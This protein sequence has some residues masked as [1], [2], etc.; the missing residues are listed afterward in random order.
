MLLNSRRLCLMGTVLP[1]DQ[2]QQMSFHTF[3]GS[4]CIYGSV[5]FGTMLPRS[6]PSDRARQHLECARLLGT[7]S[8]TARVQSFARSRMI[9]SLRFVRQ[10]AIP[11]RILTATEKQAIVLL[12]VSRNSI[13]SSGYISSVWDVQISARHSSHGIFEE[14]VPIPWCIFTTLATGWPPVLGLQS[15]S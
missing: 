12:V 8:L 3:G 14:C 15:F 13:A 6:S 5:L 1:L 2:G 7:L 10:E 11:D 9:S 4:A